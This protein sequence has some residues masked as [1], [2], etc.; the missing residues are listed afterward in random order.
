MQKRR[1]LPLTRVVMVFGV[2]ASGLTGIVGG[3]LGT[4][5]LF[6][7]TPNLAGLAWTLHPDIMVFGFLTLFI[8][9]V[10]TS[11][12]PKLN[13]AHAHPKLGFTSTL[14]LTLATLLWL[15]LQATPIVGDLALLAS[16]LF[17]LTITA[18]SIRRPRNTL[19]YGNIYIAAGA[20]TLTLLATVKVFTD[21]HNPYAE[22]GDYAYTWLAVAG[23]PTSMILGVWQHTAHFRGVNPRRML[24]A[25]SATLWCTTL[26]TYS[27]SLFTKTY[28][29]RLAEAGAL[30]GVAAV[31]TFLHNLSA[32]TPVTPPSR[33]AFDPNR[34]RYTWFDRSIR[35]ASTWLAVGVGLQALYSTG[36]GWGYLGGVNIMDAWVHTTT[37]GFYLIVISGY[38]PILL[39][40]MLRGEPSSIKPTLIPQI[41]VSV[42]V[43]LRIIGDL[44]PFISHYT[45]ILRDYSSLP[46]F[47]A[48]I[49]Y[50]LS[51]HGRD[52]HNTKGA[53]ITRT[54]GKSPLSTPAA[55]YTTSTHKSGPKIPKANRSKILIKKNILS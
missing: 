28:A 43:G 15:T 29:P 42:G 46:V 34:W 35:L 36:F 13:R 14:L 5:L 52:A 55:R 32:F 23:F 19:G 44:L 49:L 2:G 1:I 21:T 3:V 31:A 53:R 9:T 27:L 17:F 16:T 51:L 4:L 8:C 48:V 30:V 20:L 33:W 38:A 7:S 18:T 22:W 25:V 6:R 47:A 10:A 54:L 11:L 39:P 12:L 40:V 37:V 45:V 50:M 41:L 24:S 26:T